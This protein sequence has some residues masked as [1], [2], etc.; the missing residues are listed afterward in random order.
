M[1]GYKLLI[2]IQKNGLLWISSDRCGWQAGGHP[3]RQVA[4]ENGP[5]WPVFHFQAQLPD[6]R[7]RT[8]VQG[9][10]TGRQA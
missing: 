1:M 8:S 4:V 10:P 5:L 7:P 9:M 3:L 2:Y 6:P